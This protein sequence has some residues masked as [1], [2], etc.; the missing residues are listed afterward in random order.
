MS[1]R[2]R[3]LLLSFVALLLVCLG[4]SATAQAEAGP[5][6]E[7]REGAEGE[8]SEIAEAMP[9]EVRGG[10][11]EQKLIGKIAGTAF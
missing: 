8:A 7:Q 10:G 4:V 3:S 2:A 11:G 5:F 6:F 1:F 9:E